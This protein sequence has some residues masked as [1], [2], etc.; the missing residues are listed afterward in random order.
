M[1]DI[2]SPIPINVLQP[3]QQETFAASQ[4]KQGNAGRTKAID[5]NK[6]FQMFYRVVDLTKNLLES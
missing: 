1:V 3:H 6:C 4:W 5:Y 2:V